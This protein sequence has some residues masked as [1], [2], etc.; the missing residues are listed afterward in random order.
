[1]VARN[2]C[3]QVGSRGLLLMLSLLA[4]LVF[5][6]VGEASVGLLEVE[7]LVSYQRL[8]DLLRHHVQCIM[9]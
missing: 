9:L 8:N 3:H 2:L 1:M 4:K 7:M 6:H 5:L